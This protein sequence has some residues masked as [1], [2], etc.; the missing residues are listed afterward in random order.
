MEEHE[1]LTRKGYQKIIGL[2]DVRPDYTDATIKD[3]ET[4]LAKYIKTKVSPVVFILA[5][6]EIE[7]WFLAEATH[8]P[9][10]HPTIT[11]AAIKA[12][13]GFDPRTRTWTRGQPRRA[14]EKESRYCGENL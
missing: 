14:S 9:R 2:R 5:V 7:A 4:M 13:L 1:N 10:I 3:L 6:L 8:F 12:A 11:I